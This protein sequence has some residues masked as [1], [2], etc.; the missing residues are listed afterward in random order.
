V[1]KKNGGAMMQT[2]TR[3]FDKRRGSALL[4]VV[5]VTVLL[6]VVGVMFVMVARVG[7]METSAVIDTRDLNTAVESVVTRIHTVLVEDL[8]GTDGQM[9][10]GGNDPDKRG[11]DE[12]WDYGQHEIRNLSRPWQ[13]SIQ[14]GPKPGTDDDVWL[15]GTLDDIWLASLEPWYDDN[16]TPANPMDDVYIWPQITDLWGVL[17]GRPD[18]LYHQQFSGTVHHPFFEGNPGKQWVDPPGDD[19]K[20]VDWNTIKWNTYGVSAYRVIPKIIKPGSRTGVVWDGKD[21]SDPTHFAIFGARADADGDGVA[22]SRWVKAPNLTTSRGKPVF[23]AVRIIDNAAMLNLNTAFGFYQNT[24]DIA[25]WHSKPWFVSQIHVNNNLPY[26]TNA[27]FGSGLGRVLG[28]V[29]YAPFLRGDDRNMVQ[30]LRLARDPIIGAKTAQASLT[31]RD[32][33]NNVILKI[34]SPGSDYTLFGIDDELEMRN[35]YMI[36]SKVEARFERQDVANFTLDA[37]G[38]LYAPLR[39][40]VTDDTAFDMWKRR[41]TPTNFDDT[42]TPVSLYPYYYDRRH[43][44]TFYSFDRPLRSGP[45]YLADGTSLETRPDVEKDSFRPAGFRPLDLRT[46]TSQFLADGVTPNPERI[47][48]NTIGARRNILFLLYAFRAAFLPTDY[49]ALSEAERRTEL[50]KAARKSAQWVANLMDYL[51]ADT[52]ATTGPF[53]SAAYGTQMNSRPTYIN[54]ALVRRLIQDITTL[55][56]T[57]VDIGAVASTPLGRHEF[58]LGID[59]AAETVYGFERQ[60]F[61]SE[62]YCYRQPVGPTAGQVEQFGL[63]LVNPY[64]ATVSLEGWR[65]SIGTNNYD[66]DAAYFVPAASGVQPAQFGRL[67]IYAGSPPISGGQ[68]VLRSGFGLGVQLN[69]EIIVLRRPDPVNIGQYISV[70]QTRLAQSTAIFSANGIRVSKRDDK[71]WKFSNAAAY[72]AVDSVGT[73]GQANNVDTTLPRPGVQLPI[74][75]ALTP[76]YT[77]DELT[78][79]AFVSS[80]AGGTAPKTITEIVAAAA[81]DESAIRLDI[82]TVP[83]VLDYVTFLNRPK[84]A[85]LPGRINLNT[86]PLHVLA[87][88]IPPQVVMTTTTDPVHALALAQQIISNRPYE[89]V[90][91]LLKIA[92]FRKFQTDMSV[93]VGDQQMLGDLEE[94]DWIV[95]RLSNIFTVRSDTFT[96]WILVRLGEDGPERRM[97]AIFDRSQCWTP[98]DRPKLVALHPVADPR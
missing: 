97:I 47:T 93:N 5:V 4:L 32:Y 19:L 1:S 83:Q 18:S 88:A 29:N 42:G 54:R 40:P 10:T 75:D 15:P 90:S 64:P 14:I 94:R 60:P 46:M 22:D 68:S 95:S 48:A 87:A 62:I 33:F 11:A 25:P 35:R 82:R 49:P 72:A 13:E 31:A 16:K 23:V 2:I 76:L 74:A 20:N 24:S 67:T 86:A 73:L 37:G 45:Y 98:T 30:R 89:R 65:I 79:V 26:E 91:D 57:P 80:Q 34:E 58:G 7:E 85:S 38:A 53:G 50:Q 9:L 84:L 70:D 61:I 59:D 6:A 17:Q 51:D 36:A 56:G 69:N 96:A 92:A 12:R 71:E 39:T 63:E 27:D 28:E 3:Q 81:G 43:I 66:L 78:K 77:F 8:F 41:L 55:M 21:G 52:P 44:S